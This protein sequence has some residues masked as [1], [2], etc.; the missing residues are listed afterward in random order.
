MHQMKQGSCARTKAYGLGVPA[1]L[2]NEDYSTGSPEDEDV[3]QEAKEGEAQRVRG[4]MKSK[5]RG[6][7]LSLAALGRGSVC[8]QNRSQVFSSTDR[9]LSGA[10]AATPGC[11]EEGAKVLTGCLDAQDD[12]GRPH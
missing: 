12:P 7:R 4:A 11:C 2:P 5:C 6:A 10:G 9:F 8:S 3:A 1:Q